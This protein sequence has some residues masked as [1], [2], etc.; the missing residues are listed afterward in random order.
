MEKQLSY[1]K[2]AG[3]ISQKVRVYIKEIVKPGVPILELARKIHDKIEGLGAIS[4]FPVNLSIDDIAAHNHPNIDNNEKAEGLL[5][6][7]YG[8]SVDGY[9]ADSAISIDLTSDNEH[10]DIIEATEYAL[11]KALNL[12]K[13]NPTINEIGLTIQKAIESKGFLPVVNLSGHSIDR[14]KVHAG[15]TIPNYGNNN[16]NKLPPGVYAIEPFATTG[17]GKVYNGQSGNI[18]E[19]INL[20]KTRS[21]K[22]REI[23]DYVYEKYKTLPFSLR[24]VQEKFGP[25]VRLALLELENQG[26]VK[27]HSQLVE[28]SHKP[29]TQAE[30]TFIKTENGKIII[31]TREDS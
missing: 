15:I 21:Q 23:L 14:Y 10:K 20:K 2:K 9:I 31:I 11:N 1:Y 26:I 13:D 29:V 8:I 27:S 6:I 18:Y 19:I 17:E 28:K 4:A 12:L 25:M 16:E 5:K 22:A 7:D 24:E 30:H 3:K